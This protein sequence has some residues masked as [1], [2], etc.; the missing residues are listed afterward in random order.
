M[1]THTYF[2]SGKA[3]AIVAGALMTSGALVFVVGVFVGLL[4]QE[5]VQRATGGSIREVAPGPTPIASTEGVTALQRAE[6][7]AAWP[8]SVPAPAT[9]TPAA[10]DSDATEAPS[11]SAPAKAK[12][13][14]KADSTTHR[15]AVTDVAYVVP[16]EEPAPRP[17]VRDVAPYTVRV[18]SFRVERNAR[19]LVGRLEAAGYK[20]VESVRDEGGR[21]LHVVTV[22][23]YVG[24]RA[25]IFAAERIGD[26]EHLVASAVPARAR[27]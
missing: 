25:A 20:P 1:K 9:A 14:A 27:R 15:R 24:R 18:G 22:G 16:S 21:E 19:L 8:F 7:P 11:D 17:Q 6:S 13:K 4:I 23:G 12:P 3:I 10:A 26:N 5:P 2:L